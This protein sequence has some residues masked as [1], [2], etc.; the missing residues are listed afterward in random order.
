MFHLFHGQ[1]VT[2]KGASCI[3]PVL[4]LYNELIL[5]YNAKLIWIA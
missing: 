3:I 5:F 1:S 2:L 4:G